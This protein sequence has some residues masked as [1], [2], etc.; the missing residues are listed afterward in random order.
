MAD[1]R[2]IVVETFCISGRGAV[3]VLN[4]CTELPFRRALRA[5]VFL[6]DGTKFEA[7]ASK[8]LM[9]RRIPVPSEVEAFVLRDVEKGS[10]PIGS[11]VE[12][13]LE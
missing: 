5:T 7:R 13:R 6:A 9:L 8:E 3:V 4:E 1:L 10:V 11:L 12:I 2:Y